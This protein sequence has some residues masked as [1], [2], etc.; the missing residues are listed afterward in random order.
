[1]N[2]LYRSGIAQVLLRYCSGMFDA[3]LYVIVRLGEAL[4][5]ITSVVASTVLNGTKK[6]MFFMNP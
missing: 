1:M 4:T 6:I 5:Y 3:S 2:V